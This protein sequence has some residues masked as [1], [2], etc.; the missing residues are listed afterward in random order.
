MNQVKRSVVLIREVSNDATRDGNAHSKDVNEDEE[1]ILH[2]VSK[3]DQEK[4]FEHKKILEI[5]L[6][7]DMTAFGC[8]YL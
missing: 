3:G 7:L 1:L 4:V 6:R 2:H 5:Y 8:V